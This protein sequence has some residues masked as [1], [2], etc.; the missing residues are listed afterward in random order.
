MSKELTYYVSSLQFHIM[1]KLGQIVVKSD[2]GINIDKKGRQY[3][4][5]YGMVGKKE[6]IIKVW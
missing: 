1:E 2:L 4:A 5:F 3:R 6:R